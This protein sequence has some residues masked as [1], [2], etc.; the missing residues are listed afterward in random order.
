MI[1]S[2]SIFTLASASQQAVPPAKEILKGILKKIPKSRRFDRMDWETTERKRIKVT[3]RVP[4]ICRLYRK[5]KAQ[6]LKA[7]YDN[8]IFLFFMLFFFAFLHFDWT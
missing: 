8:L 4:F 7:K 5:K 1:C 6:L 3:L 2:L